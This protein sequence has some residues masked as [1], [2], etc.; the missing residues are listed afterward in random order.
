DEDNP[1][2]RAMEQLMALLYG[3]DHPYGRR[4]KGTIESV[5]RLTRSRLQGLPSAHFAPS[6]LTA[7]IVGDADATRIVDVATSVF[8][9]WTAKAA[10]LTPLPPAPSATDRRRIVIP[11]MNKS[12]TEIAYG[13]TTIT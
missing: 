6:E 5:E 1:A 11:M 4:S 10:P 12:Q 7:V 13:F 3:P 8:G 9:G 2:V